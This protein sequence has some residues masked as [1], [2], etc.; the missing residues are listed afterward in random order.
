MSP[1]ASV[2][3]R[4]STGRYPEHSDTGAAAGGSGWFRPLALWDVTSAIVSDD[5][6]LS[7]NDV[8]ARLVQKGLGRRG[9]GD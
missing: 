2:V 6:E 4:P 7:D 5:E 3:R 1:A 9:G 8:I